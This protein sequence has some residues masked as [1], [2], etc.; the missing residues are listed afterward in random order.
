MYNVS[1]S[2]H[3][4]SPITTRAIMGD[5]IIA[6]LPP[7]VFG[8]I[9]FSNLFG[10]EYGVRS[11]LLILITV[12]ACVLSE[13]VFNKITKRASTL[14]DLSA[15]VTGMI[16]ALN[17]PCT[18]TYWKAALGGVFAI[19]IVKQ[20]FG[21]LG[22]N[23]MNPALG[24]RCFLVLSFAGNM[25]AFYPEMYKIVDGVSQATPLTAMKNGESVNLLSMFVGTHAG[26]I[27]ETSIIALLIGALYLVIN[28]IID[29]RIPLTYIIVFSICI[30]FFNGKTDIT[31]LLEHLCGG[32]LI[33]G[34]FFMATDYCTSPMTKS[35]RIIFGICLGVLTAIFRTYGNTAEGVSFAIIF[36][37][38]LV[39]LIEKITI[40]KAFGIVK[41]K[42]EGR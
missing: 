42:K 6:L 5:V 33:F 27:G 14:D 18:F 3:V 31:F 13:F 20:L 16:L 32:G 40:P 12:A 23:F 2:P 38:L 30:M 28:K 11:A 21:G 4:K 17:L 37:N 34:A 25:T 36:C 35:G 24:A 41:V 7:A 19:I 15:I 9:N 29:L 10:I 39:P 1:S 8:I 22:Q 26:T